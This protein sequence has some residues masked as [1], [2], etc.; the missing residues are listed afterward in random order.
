MEESE[1]RYKTRESFVSELAFVLTDHDIW[2][3][4][5]LDVT[6]QI[7]SVIQREDYSWGS[8]GLP[9]ATRS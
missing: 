9:R 5:Y 6:Q 8:D 1:S 4:Q 2:E 7:L 3:E